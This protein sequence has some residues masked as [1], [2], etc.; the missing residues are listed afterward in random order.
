MKEVLQVL[1]L[2]NGSGSGP[3]L[4]SVIRKNVL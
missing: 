3:E 1:K 2:E 4:Y